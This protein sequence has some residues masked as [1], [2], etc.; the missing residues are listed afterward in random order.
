MGAV[1]TFTRTPRTEC[2]LVSNPGAVG[3][4][5]KYTGHQGVINHVQ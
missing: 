4:H 3:R 5:Q 1:V 2:G